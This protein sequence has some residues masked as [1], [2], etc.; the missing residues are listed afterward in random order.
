F[1]LG[2]PKVDLGKVELH[3]QFG[4]DEKFKVKVNDILVAKAH[5]TAVSAGQEFH[6]GSL[7]TLRCGVHGVKSISETIPLAGAEVEVR[8]RSAAGKETSLYKGK[9]GAQGVA[10]ASF[11]MPNVP[12]GQ[13]TLVVATKSELGE[14]KLEQPIK[15]KAE[16]KI[17]LVTDKPLYQPG[18]EIHIR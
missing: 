7:A 18:Q 2:V 13:Y 17:L 12:A 4:N 6:S 9:A 3:F 16:A 8:L 5:E 14:E 1:E 15:V 11:K 10:D